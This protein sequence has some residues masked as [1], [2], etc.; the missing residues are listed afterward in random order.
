LG[1][2]P[3]PVGLD[4]DRL[5]ANADELL[6]EPKLDPSR[7]GQRLAITNDNTD[8]PNLRAV[9]MPDRLRRARFFLTAS[10]RA[11]ETNLY[12][13][14]R[15]SLWPV[16][17][18]V[19]RR[20]PFDQLAAF[21]ST[22]ADATGSSASST[23]GF[24][25]Q[26]RDP[27]SPRNDFSSI[28]RN[29]DVY[30]YL[31]TLINLD[32]PGFGGN[33][34]A[35]WGDDRDQVL[36]EIFDYIRCTNL[37]DPQQT[38]AMQFAPNGQVAPIVIRSARGFDSKG[39]GRFHTISQAG[40]HFICTYDN[41]Q[42][43]LGTAPAATPLGATD[44]V[45]E[46]AFIFTPFSPSVGWPPLQEQM[47]IQVIFPTAGSG[48]F[49]VIDNRNRAQPLNFRNAGRALSNSIGNGLFLT[50]RNKGGA[51][52]LRGTIAGLGG[53][54]YPWIS[55]RV[56]V[57]GNAP[58]Q[59]TGGTVVMKLFSGNAPIAANLVQTINITIPNGT[60]PVPAI[61]PAT[62]GTL[63]ARST[64]ATAPSFWWSLASRYSRTPFM[65]FLPSTAEYSNAVRCW[66]A[67]SAGFPPGFKQ[68]S[69]FRS[70]D[71]VRSVVPAHGDIRLIAAQTV[72]PGTD[73]VPADDNTAAQWNSA[74]NRFAHLF[75]EPAGTQ[76]SY[77][78]LNEPGTAPPGLGLPGSRPGDQLTP[79]NYHYS[80][81]PEIRPGAGTA[82]NHWGD[83][84]NGVAQTIDGAYINKPDEGNL[85]GAQGYPY[86]SSSFQS[87]T[88]NYFSPNRLIPSAGMLG[89]LPTG[90]RRTVTNPSAPHAWETLLFRPDVS[91]PPGPHPGAASPPDHL[92]MD[93]FWMPVV[94][95][96]AISEPFSTAGKVNM[97][98]EIAPFN[99]IHRATALV[100]ALKGEE[101][102]AIPTNALPGAPDGAAKI[103]KL[104]DAETADEG[105][106]PNPHCLDAQVRRDWDTAYTGAAP[107]NKMRK[108]IDPVKTLLPFEAKFLQ[109][110]LFRSATQI[111]EMHLPRAGS[112]DDGV[113]PELPAQYSSGRFWRDHVV[114]GDNTRER[115]YANLYAK[116]TTRSNS[117]TVHIRAQVLRQIGGRGK[118]GWATW[119]EDTD[120]QVAEYRGS[121]L[122]ERYIDPADRTLADFALQPNALVDNAYR[123]RIV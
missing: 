79:A 71:V 12:G 38:G 46:S 95:P 29:R 122:L 91:Q 114:T 117:F 57:S 69:I 83:F 35:K 66:P 58:L 27:V 6:F 62:G 20:T 77:G 106:L 11:P 110:Q 47:F 98:Y 43:R 123:L 36:T 44:R 56:I 26:R 39:F 118:L 41:A 103:Y 22:I 18:N 23:R 60:F 45:I 7:S 3:N 31:Q 63:P 33:F 108:R 53:A 14:P 88:A 92:L 49:T 68:G 30:S 119:R 84:D 4:K 48:A 61:V 100:G 78:F 81:L 112:L 67:D 55:A 86:W 115:P 75:V 116:L 102:L 96:Y 89:S 65:P 80:R 54:V 113:T 8:L 73:W 15:V 2:A 21:C 37:R 97:N 16:H 24:Y 34:R 87:P 76:F 5:F 59:F 40:L 72:V 107:F 90:V 25:F 42:P 50:G 28:A 93:L 85:S 94:E 70:E 52:G 121:T 64:P 99:Y 13:Q 109:G 32:V 17:A 111:C 105:W 9:L 1:G 101:P 82:F 10:S 51:G 74:T 104:W 120:Q 19:A